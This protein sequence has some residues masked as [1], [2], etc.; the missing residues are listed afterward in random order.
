MAT[1]LV[2][3]VAGNFLSALK[4]PNPSLGAS[5]AVFGLVGAYF[6]FLTRNEW[7]LGTYGDTMTGAITQTIAANVIL[8]AV[9]PVIDNWAHLGGLMGGAAM[10]YTFGPRL[11]LAD[12]P[13][14]G[15]TLVD[16]PIVRLPRS[17]EEFPNRVGDQYQRL[18]RR[19]QIGR[20]MSDLPEKPWRNKARP[21]RRYA[22]N[23]SI[24]PLDVT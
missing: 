6:V 10:A 16:Q 19:M 2:A 22:P 7:L 1:Y 3:G 8:G 9:N 14:G 21:S 13:D 15:R 17:V 20:Y 24:K 23:R 4:S 5:G 11:Y 12:L 18:V